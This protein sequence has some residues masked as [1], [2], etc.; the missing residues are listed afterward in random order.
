MP[1]Y[2]LKTLKFMNRIQALAAE[3]VEELKELE[4]TA[5]GKHCSRCITNE[6]TRQIRAWKAQL[7]IVIHD[8]D[9][10]QEDKSLTAHYLEKKIADRIKAEA[11]QKKALSETRYDVEGET[12]RTSSWTHSVRGYHAKDSIYDFKLENEIYSSSGTPRY[13]TRPKQMARDYHESTQH[14]ETPDE[15]ARMMATEITLEKC[16]LRLS[17]PEFNDMDNDLTIEDIE[18]ALR[19]S[20]NGKAPGFDGIPYKLY[21]LLDILY[22]QS[23]KTKSET[24]N[25]LAFLTKLYADI[26]QYGIIQGSKFNAGWLCPVFKKGDKSLISNYR[27]RT[28][29]N[30]DYKLMTKNY[31]LRLMNVAPSPVHPNQAGFMKGRKF[32]DPVKLAKFILNYAEAAEVDGIIVA[33]DQEKAYDRINH[34]Y[35]LRVLQHMGFPNKFCNTIRSLYNNAETVVIIN[36]EISELFIVARGV[37]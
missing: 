10:P 6:T 23:R 37:R 32:E 29:L 30:C 34:T 2:L 35:L 3:L 21:K 36:G 13:E 7:T 26:E 14:K 1:L 20:H 28:L 24:F 33:L 5:R 15:Y 27:P 18:E 9:M 31:S 19:L 25:I 4:H 22:R 16:N 11:E 8:L 17:E 12:L